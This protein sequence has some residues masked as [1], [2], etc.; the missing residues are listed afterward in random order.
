[1]VM[2]THSNQLLKTFCNKLLW[3]E[4]GRLKAFGPTEEILEAYTA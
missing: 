2:A 1:V 4:H 3:L